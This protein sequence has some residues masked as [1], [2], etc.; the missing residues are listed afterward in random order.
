MWP[1]YLRRVVSN[2]KQLTEPSAKVLAAVQDPQFLIH[3]NPLVIDAT[4]DPTD[5][6]LF[7]IRDRLTVLGINTETSYTCKFTQWENGVDTET[8]AG[9]G[10]TL[11][12]AWRVIPGSDAEHCEVTEEV[13]IE[14]LFF[15]MPYILSTFKT[16][17]QA[18]LD[19]LADNVGQYEPTLATKLMDA[20]EYKAGHRVLDVGHGTGESLVFLLSSD[21]IPRPSSLTGVTSLAVHHQRSA[22][23][24][25]KLTTT[26]AREAKP[27]VVLYHGDAVYRRTDLKHPLDPSQGPVFDTILAL[28]CAYHF[29]TRRTFLTQCR[30]KLAH[31]G[32]VALAD[33]CFSPPSLT[34]RN[35]IAINLLRLMPKRN[36]ISTSGYVEMMEEIGY[37]DITF[38]D[39]S[40]DV[41]PAF[42]AFLSSRGSGWAV[43]ARVLSLY[44]RL[45]ARFVI[46]SAIQAVYIRGYEERSEPKSHIVYRIEIQAHVRSWQMWRRYS[47][48]DDLHT[49][50]TKSTGSPPPAPLPPK[51]K[52]SV[53]RSRSDPKLLED[54]RLG[55]EAYLR[56][57][58]SAKD[59][60]WREE[61]VFKEFLGVPIGRQGGVRGGPPTQFSSS[62]WLDEHIELQALIRDIRADINKRDALADRNDVVAAHKSNVSAKQKLAGVL[63]RVGTLAGGLQELASGGM[64]EGE[65]QRRTDMVSRLQDECEK[66]GKMVSIAKMSNRL[67]TS[68]IG[69]SAAL[70][71]APQS[72]REALLGSTASTRPFSRV[73]GAKQP[74]Q[75]TEQTR[76][77]DDHGVLQLQ[78]T[79]IQEQDQHLSALTTILQRQRHLGEAIGNE[80]SLQNE[81]LDDLNNEVDRVGGKMSAANKQMNRLR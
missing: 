36:I 54:R 19:N 62:S 60:K 10:T 31:G 30:H 73:F 59:D 50:L 66:L 32:R 49:E 80:I 25:Q 40:E 29:D 18:L 71:P 37:V 5:P 69:G 41:F 61:F 52:L 79:Q 9:L 77:L 39:I 24:I 16:S 70:N 42:T 57:I 38:E 3:L 11:D 12:A 35:R 6:T 4:V 34:P 78:Q 46:V 43:F 2:S 7:T 27:A 23:R 45:G 14:A 13:T 15:M 55:L 17:H 47:E 74:A 56:A 22:E 72:E 81:M 53:F 65:L 8:K 68:S 21:K 67:A 75:E 48:F 51:Q 64:S 26:D 33:I 63:T 20:A 58:V 1:L 44:V 76:P 28:D